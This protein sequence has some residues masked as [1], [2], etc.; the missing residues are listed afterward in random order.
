MAAT[1]RRALLEAD[2]AVGRVP[3]QGVDHGEA[4]A[5]TIVAAAWDGRAVTVGWAGDSR[6]YWIGETESVRL[7]VDHSWAQQQVDAQLLDRETAEADPRA[8]TITS[9]LGADAPSRGQVVEHHPTGRGL[10]VVCSD[11]LWNYAGEIDELSALV[12]S[13]P[14]ARPAEV[15]GHLVRVALARGGRDNV[16]VGVIAVDPDRA[17]GEGATARMWPG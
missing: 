12:R 14:T 6:A 8:H 7:T 17:V 13:A 11:G 4:P 1:V 10:L 16:T 5:C 9:W 3:W 2:H 15:A